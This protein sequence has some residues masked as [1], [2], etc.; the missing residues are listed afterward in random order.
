MPI[1]LFNLLFNIHMS[2]HILQTGWRTAAPVTTFQSTMGRLLV[3]NIWEKFATT[4]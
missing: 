3:H 4:V 1:F 2:W